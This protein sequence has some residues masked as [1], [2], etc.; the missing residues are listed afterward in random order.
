MQEIRKISN[1]LRLP[2][3][4]FSSCLDAFLCIVRC[5][6]GLSNFLGFKM[7][8]ELIVS[9]GLRILRPHPRSMPF[10]DLGTHTL[11]GYLYCNLAEC[12]HFTISSVAVLQGAPA[13]Y[14]IELGGL[15]WLDVFF[16]TSVY[17]LC[18][19]Y[20][21]LDLYNFIHFQLD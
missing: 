17:I 15:L 20:R 12:A 16:S 3:F 2:H 7:G 9:I 1:K 11:S 6:G 8:C 13:L 14:Q 19:H 21:R 4:E 5:D 18:N 10:T